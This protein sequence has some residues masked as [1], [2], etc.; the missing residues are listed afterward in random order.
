MI[1]ELEPCECCGRR[2]ERLAKA[3]SSAGDAWLIVK[4][5][6]PERLIH[7]AGTS[8]TVPKPSIAEQAPIPTAGEIALDARGRANRAQSRLLRLEERVQ[9]LEAPR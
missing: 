5:C 9:R 7:Y 4:C 8:D 6:G 1:S 2:P 3:E